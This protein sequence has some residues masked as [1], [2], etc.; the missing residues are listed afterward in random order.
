MVSCSSLHCSLFT[1]PR[2]SKHYVRY[3]KCYSLEVLPA[4]S[5]F[6]VTE[7]VVKSWV[8][9]YVFLHHPGQFLDN[10]SKTKIN[11]N[12]GIMTFIDMSYEIDEDTLGEN[13]ILPCQKEMDKNFDDC[14]S[15]KA[16]EYLLSSFNC[17]VP[18]L[19]HGGDICDPYDE[20]LR[21]NVTYK[22]EYIVA[23]GQRQLCMK[24]CTSMEVSAGELRGRKST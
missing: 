12:V 22:Y 13:S 10:N 16:N 1:R 3:G 8:D 15:R 19:P 24:P 4:A 2:K 7:F 6:G 5:K 17:T 18:Y 23:E 21:K 9:I 11:V 20:Q 14:V